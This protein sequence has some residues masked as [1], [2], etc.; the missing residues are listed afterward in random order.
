MMS[1]LLKVDSLCFLI[2]LILNQCLPRIDEVPPKKR[3][4]NSSE[5][6]DGNAVVVDT[7]TPDEKPGTSSAEDGVSTTKTLS[8]SVICQTTS[9]EQATKAAAP[10]IIDVDQS[11]LLE[12]EAMATLPEQATEH[13]I[14]ITN[15]T[16]ST[17]EN[18]ANEKPAISDEVK[19]KAIERKLLKKIELN[20]H[21]ILEYFDGEGGGGTVHLHS[22][23][24]ETSTTTA[25]ISNAPSSSQTTSLAA[26][27]AETESSPL[28]EL[29]IIDGAEQ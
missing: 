17:L 20:L 8:N 25:T 15:T 18:S 29:E 4:L 19:E 21:T 3:K 27:S 22:T 26:T 16:T 1:S 2:L 10:E 11:Q 13:E 14:P 5:C 23:A 12:D 9:K 24:A 28:E 7:N 6:E